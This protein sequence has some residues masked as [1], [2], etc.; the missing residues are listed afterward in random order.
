MVT[1]LN[2]FTLGGMLGSGTHGSN[3]VKK[4]ALIADYVTEM[5]IVDGY[6]NLRILTGEE[7]DLARVNLGVLGIVV[8][9]TI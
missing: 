8:E 3:L 5:K 2:I 7:L 4:S 9:V 1:E 6:G